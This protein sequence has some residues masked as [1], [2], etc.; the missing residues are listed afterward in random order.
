[1][2]ALT[3]TLARLGLVLHGTNEDLTL[4][5]PVSSKSEGE[6][7]EDD[8][9]S[10]ESED[11]QGQGSSD[12][13]PEE[14]DDTDGDSNG[15]E[16]PEEGEEED[17][18]EGEEEDAQ[19][20]AEGD[21]EEGEE[22]DDVGSSDGDPE[23]GE[24]D[25]DSDSDE[26]DGDA[27]PGGSSGDDEGDS[28]GE[29]PDSSDEGPG[30]PSD[31]S[32]EG[33]EGEGDEAGEGNEE[34][35][36]GSSPAGMNPEE[37]KTLAEELIEAIMEGAD[38]GLVDNNETLGEALGDKTDEAMEDC[39]ANEQIWRPYYPDLDLVEVVTEGDATTARRMKGK[40]L[41]E[42]AF[43]RAQMR[44]KF[45]QARTPKVLHGVRKGDDLSE[46]RLV[47]SVVELRS[48]RR[49]TRPDWR[50]I[51]AEDCS[52]AAAVVLDQSGSMGSR[53]AA[54]VGAAAIAIATPLDELGAPCLVI[55]PRDDGRWTPDVPYGALKSKKYHR[56]ET[57]TID[58]FKDWEEPMRACLD[59]FSRVQS[60][61]GTPL[62]DGIQYAMQYINERPERHRV[63]LVLTDG[64]PSRPDVVNRQIRL[65]REAGVTIVGVGIS[66]GCLLVKRMFPD[67]HVAVSKLEQLPKELLGV[68]SGIMFPKKAKRI[69]LDE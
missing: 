23:E 25:Q 54:K 57:V 60:V 8:Q 42:I 2:T 5:Q 40:V 22:S 7:S 35:N 67:N 3:T 62:S 48:G 10:E 26:E 14:S 32:D 29:D 68:L 30:A 11:D 36:E 55:G 64:M 41:K 44:N 13:D 59:R 65:A 46:R 63:I 34:G 38:T 47:H 33:E 49:P 56:D 52:L 28:E 37:L 15:D 21:P 61:G 18:E 43:L 50:R 20:S 45:L 24:D 12:G 19:G 17:P 69:I 27:E 6:E 53:L 9:D 39:Q 1:M 4:T 58:V 31:S 16:D 66:D 51:P